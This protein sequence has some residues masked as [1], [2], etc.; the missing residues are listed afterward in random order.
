MSTGNGGNGMPATNEPDRRSF[1][2]R[3]KGAA[4]LEARAYEEVEHD[5]AATGQAALVVALVALAHAL[6]AWGAGPFEMLWAAG[7]QL[8]G[9]AILAGLAFLIGTRLFGGTATWGEVFRTL[10]F[11]QAPGLLYL[12]AFLPLIGWVI[13]A[14]TTLWIL[15]ASVVAIRQALD[16]TTERAV[17]TGI[18]SA[19]GWILLTLVF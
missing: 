6:G 1:P 10:G 9:V 2:A 13:A 17:I 19:G 8:V 18:L 12:L 7:A 15:W 5:V 11:A 3:M 14:V 16:V 4:L